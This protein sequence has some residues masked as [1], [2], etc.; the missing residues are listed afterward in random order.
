MF[1]N[2]AW[3]NNPTIEWNPLEPALPDESEPRDGDICGAS[4]VISNTFTDASSSYLEECIQT[5]LSTRHNI[6]SSSLALKM[7]LSVGCPVSHAR[8]VSITLKPYATVE[9][10]TSYCAPPVWSIHWKVR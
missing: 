3:K 7:G 6:N 9:R 4:L 8:R 1:R 5:K 10:L 2:E